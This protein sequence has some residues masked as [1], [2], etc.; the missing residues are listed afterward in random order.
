MLLCMQVHTALGWSSFCPHSNQQEIL[1]PVELVWDRL[2]WDG[3]PD[4]PTFTLTALTLL[5]LQAPGS[6]RAQGLRV[7]LVVRP[8]LASLAGP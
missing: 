1:P 6:K 7:P 5:Q 2:I 3:L 4:S 8:G